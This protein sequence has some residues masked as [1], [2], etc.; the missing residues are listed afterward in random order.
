MKELESNYN[1]EREREREWERE[2]LK[3][4]NNVHTYQNTSIFYAKHLF[5]TILY[6]KFAVCLKSTFKHGNQLNTS[7]S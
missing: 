3:V 6:I 1:G 2:S 4:Y 5:Y 7:S